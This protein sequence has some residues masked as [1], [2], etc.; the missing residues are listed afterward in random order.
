MDERQAQIKDRAGLEESRVNQEFVAFIQKYAM[1]AL[2]V[3]AILA[4]G[5][6]GWQWLQ[7]RRVDR[8]NEAFR[9]LELAGT[10]ETASPDTLI[11]IAGDFEDVKGVAI[12]ARLRA[13]DAYMIAVR[14][15]VHPGA[16]LNP[17]GTLQNETDA[18]TD[19]SRSF[20]LDNAQREYETVRQKT[21]GKPAMAIHEIRAL[22]GLAA[23]AETRDD[24]EAAK[25]YYE[26]V[27]SVAEHNG[28]TP[29]PEIA[30][31]R[32]ETLPQIQNV[33]HL[34]AQAELPPLPWEIEPAPTPDDGAIDDGAELDPDA[35]PDGDAP[36][37]DAPAG[38]AETPPA[39][40]EDAPPP[41]GEEAGEQDAPP[42]AGAES[43]DDG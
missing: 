24:V 18:V 29:H 12:L 32:I 13:A 7:E 30:R 8:A 16:P 14:R 35:A 41:A 26:N 27:I 31:E 40:D 21:T 42:P 25:R 6:R 38:D 4:F 9:Q 11:G 5:Y 17:D 10:A 33:P 22:Y 2:L 3:V 23:V 36:A 1:H 19:E 39:G 20:L 37:G 34:Y 43:D 28:L 15:G